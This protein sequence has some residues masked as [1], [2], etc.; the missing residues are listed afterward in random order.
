[1]PI[2]TSK[3]SKT[4]RPTKV[5]L[6]RDWYIV[7]VSKEPLGRV[8]TKIANLLVGKNRADYSS[9][10]DMGAMVVVINARKVV[11]TGKK[12][13]K[14]NYF[15]H[16]GRPGSLRVNSF[17]EQLAK[18]PLVPLYRAVRGMLPKN[19]HTD[20]RMHN[21]LFIFADANHNITQKLIPL[22]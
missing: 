22:N 12:S 7:D 6:Q 2:F 19:R 15:R 9:D 8:S 1:M 18:D 3:L 21:H 20:L 11:L 5:G 4:T 13:E 14:K 16:S 10:V 17:P